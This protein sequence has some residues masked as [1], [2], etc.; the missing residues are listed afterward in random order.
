LNIKF[1]TLYL[2]NQ[3]TATEKDWHSGRGVC[4]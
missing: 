1:Q 2:S 3:N 4:Q